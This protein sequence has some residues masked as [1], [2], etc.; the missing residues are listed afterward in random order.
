[1]VW[2]IAGTLRYRLRVNCSGQSDNNGSLRSKGNGMA[3]KGVVLSSM[4]ID[5][6][7]GSIGSANSV[8]L[9][10]LL[11]TAEAFDAK[12]WTYPPASPTAKH[13]HEEETSRPIH[14]APSLFT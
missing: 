2:S 14:M 10:K 12:V 11:N 1:M 4:G 7:S 9:E 3:V 6:E 5:T 8:G 13:W